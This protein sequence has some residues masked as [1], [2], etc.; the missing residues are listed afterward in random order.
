[1]YCVEN[2]LT[3]ELSGAVATLELLARTTWARAIT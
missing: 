1:M 3:N 2:G